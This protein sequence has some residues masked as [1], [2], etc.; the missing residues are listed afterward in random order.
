MDACEGVYSVIRVRV[1]TVDACV[2][3]YSVIRVRVLQWMHVR[4]CTV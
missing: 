4:V 1:C 2:G 3:V